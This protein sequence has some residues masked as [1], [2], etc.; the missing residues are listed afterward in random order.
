MP[1]SHTT[2]RFQK[3]YKK[4]RKQT[5]NSFL[6]QLRKKYPFCVH[7][8][9]KV[10]PSTYTGHKITYG[11]M[12]YEGMKTLYSHVHKLQPMIGGF[13]DVGSGR[14][15]L[16][17]YM[18]DYPEIQTSIG[19]ELVKERV[20][21]AETLKSELSKKYDAITKKVTFLNEN[22]LEIKYPDLLPP[23][24][25]PFFIWF[26]NL[27][28]EPSTTDDIIQKLCE[29]MPRGSILTCS[30]PLSKQLDKVSLLKILTI[31]MSWSSS[32]NVH[33]YRFL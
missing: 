21:D 20:H 14:G 33:V 32:S 27:C 17:L 4:T 23:S 5:T 2:R 9:G 11:E 6:E 7:D 30:K 10:C 3:K 13:M 18:A 26:S 19:I 15:K 24:S 29:E 1:S 28:F 8:H 16:C 22:A 25:R 31:P 12:N